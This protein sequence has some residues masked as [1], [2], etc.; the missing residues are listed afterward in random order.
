M[1]VRL[2]EFPPAA[3]ETFPSRCS[4]ISTARPENFPAL[5][6]HRPE[7]DG[8]PSIYAL[9]ISETSGVPNL[10]RTEPHLRPRSGSARL[11]GK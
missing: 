6:F 7:G 8:S 11:T 4:G 3:I 2:G 9:S 1:H 5:R 10:S